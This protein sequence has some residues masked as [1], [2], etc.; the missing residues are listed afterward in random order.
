MPRKYTVA[1]AAYNKKYRKKVSLH[2]KL[3]I[4]HKVEGSWVRVMY[5]DDALKVLEEKF[6]VDRTS[7]TGLSWTNS[8][9]NLKFKREKEAGWRNN[10]V[11]PYIISVSIKGVEYKIP[12][13]HAVWMLSNKGAHIDDY[14]VDHID[15]DQLNNSIENL[16]LATASQNSTNRGGWGKSKYKNVVIAKDKFRWIMG[17]KGKY[18]WSTY[19]KSKHYAAILGWDILTSGKIPLDCVRFQPKEYMD[20]TYLQRALA[21]CKKQGIAVTPPKFKTLHEYIASVEGS[22]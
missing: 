8:K 15:R 4:K 10:N 22:C 9:L 16:R 11:G 21:E 18:Y 7:R 20:G 1:R 14:R 5:P 17:I 19:T 3:N 13:A 6:V 2:R 12:V